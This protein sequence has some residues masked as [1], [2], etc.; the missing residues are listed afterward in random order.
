ML[1]V[2]VGVGK[3]EGPPVGATLCREHLLPVGAGSAR[4]AL[5][6]TDTNNRHRFSEP[7]VDHIPHAMP[8]LAA[9]ALEVG[10]DAAARTRHE[11]A[12]AAGVAEQRRRVE[13][14]AHPLRIG[15]P[16]GGEMEL[17]ARAQAAGGWPPVPRTASARCVACGAGS[18]ARDRES[19][20]APRRG[21]RARC[22]RAG[23]RRRRPRSRGH[24][25]CRA[26]R[27]R[28]TTA[29][30]PVGAPRCPDSCAPDRPP[31]PRRSPRRCRSRSR[32]PPAMESQTSSADRRPHAASPAQTAASPDP[33]PR[34]AHPWYAPGAARSCGSRGAVCR[35]RRDRARSVIP[36][37]RNSI[38]V[39]KGRKGRK[40][41]HGQACRRM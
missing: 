16:V 38:F 33:A 21:C 17:S 23:L 28:A 4:D 19:T 1:V 22:R 25:R 15:F 24:C 34:A 36:S 7:L 9:A 20:G 37:R 30:P 8:E 39:R 26:H 14:F 13:H 6:N 10:F 5:A 29:R 11:A 31:R 32:P 12:V 41:K 18:C 27:G 40:G 3:G 35:V 2:G